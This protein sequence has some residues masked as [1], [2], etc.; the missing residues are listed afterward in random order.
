MRIIFSHDP[1]PQTIL[2]RQLFC[3]G[4]TCTKLVYIPMRDRDP[5]FCSIQCALEYAQDKKGRLVAGG[6]L[7]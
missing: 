6:G 1:D 2:M 7:P 5:F 4:P 3:H